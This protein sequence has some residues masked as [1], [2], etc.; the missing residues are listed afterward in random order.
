MTWY[1]PAAAS[2]GQVMRQPAVTGVSSCSE[3]LPPSRRYVSVQLLTG[4]VLSYS[5]DL[6]CRLIEL[7]SCVTLHLN[8]HGMQDTNLFGLSLLVDGEYVF[9]DLEC[10]VGKYAPKQSRTPNSEGFDGSN[11]SILQFS[12]RVKYYVDCHLLLRDRLSRHHY[13]L[14]LREN[15]LVLRQPIRHDNSL[16]LASWALQADL[17]NYSADLG[18]NYFQPANYLPAWLIDKLGVESILDQMPALHRENI[19]MG[20]TEAQ[21][22]YIR[23]ASAF[24]AP[25]NLHV[26]RLRRRKCDLTGSVLLG[27]CPNGV[28]LYEE[29]KNHSRKLLASFVWTNIGNLSFEKRKFEIRALTQRFTFYTSCDEK[30]KLLFALCRGMHMFTQSLKERLS[31]LKHSSDDD[32]RGYYGSAAWRQYETASTASTATECWRY[33]HGMEEEDEGTGTGR[34]TDQRVSVV[35]STSSTTTSGVVSDRTTHSLESSDDETPL[36]ETAADSSE[37]QTSTAKIGPLATVPFSTSPTTHLSVSPL[38]ACKPT[39]K[40]APTASPRKNIPPSKCLLPS[41][42]GST[43]Q[44]A[45]SDSVASLC[46][47]SCCSSTPGTVQVSPTHSDPVAGCCSTCSAADANDHEEQEE[48]TRTKAGTGQH[49][50]GEVNINQRQVYP[51]QQGE[52]PDESGMQR[53]LGDSRAGAEFYNL[54]EDYDDGGVGEKLGSELAVS[55]DYS[56]HSAHTSV[57]SVVTTPG[58]FPRRITVSHTFD[59]DSDYVQVP[60]DEHGRLRILATPEPQQQSPPPP[61]P[62]PPLPL[63]AGVSSNLQGGQCIGSTSTSLKVPLKLKLSSASSSHRPSQLIAGGVAMATVTTVTNFGVAQSG[64]TADVEAGATERGSQQS[65]VVVTG[66]SREECQ[67]SGE[68]LVRFIKCSLQVTRFSAQVNDVSLQSASFAAA[69]PSAVAS[70]RATISRFCSRRRLAELVAGENRLDVCRPRPV[71][72]AASPRRQYANLNPAERLQQ[73]LLSDADYVIYPLKDPLLSRQEYVDAKHCSKRLQR[74][75]P[76]YPPPPYWQA[77]RDSV[78]LPSALATTSAGATSAALLRHQKMI[79]QHMQRTRPQ[80]PLTNSQLSSN[81]LEHASR[82]DQQPVHVLSHASLRQHDYEYVQRLAHRVREEGAAVSQCRN[83]S[84][85]TPPAS[86]IDIRQLPLISALFTDQLL[87]P[88]TRADT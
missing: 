13:Y 50:I 73:Q 8:S 39:P 28:E 83:P 77:G 46:S 87:S 34:D 2:G 66:P 5:V 36:A 38:L 6:K 26:Y 72:H 9:L 35:S 24:E 16:L 88:S 78:T 45:V 12:L 15:V 27:V 47:P 80:A 3:S 63:I 70:A 25:H 64:T 40:I 21:L 1:D 65:Q 55:V 84:T 74:P 61:P 22:A 69:I 53:M 42:D 11:Q 48:E 31:Q 68:A 76:P 52:Q 58:T 10:K 33:L 32:P 41:P 75:T 82:S 29:E 19:N 54:S 4:Q 60:Y 20:R 67:R 44:S 56:V 14:Q 86:S 23:E 81:L 51:R 57:G 18:R 7:Y 85:S 79:R 71:Q 43:C 37:N 59:T 49:E 62:P 30:A 17:G